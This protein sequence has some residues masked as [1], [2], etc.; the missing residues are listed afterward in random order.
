VTADAARKIDTQRLPTRKEGRTAG[1]IKSAYRAVPDVV[2]KIC[3]FVQPISVRQA[4]ILG[5][6][7]LELVV[8]LFRGSEPLNRPLNNDL[9]GFLSQI[10][11]ILLKK[12][13]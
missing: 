11:A 5:L 4:S 3:A 9:Y 1:V 6:G 10:L 12:G 7:L 2:A 8:E 13:R